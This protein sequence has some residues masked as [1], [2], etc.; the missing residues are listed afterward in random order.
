[1]ADL[2]RHPGLG[3]T[4]LHSEEAQSFLDWLPEMDNVQLL[5]QASIWRWLTQTRGYVEFT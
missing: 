4:I 1:M 3:H 5:R 2:V